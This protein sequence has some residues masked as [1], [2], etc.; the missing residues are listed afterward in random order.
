MD[1]KIVIT[2]AV[3]LAV[4]AGAGAV[5]IALTS[6]G[7]PQQEAPEPEQRAVKVVEST[8]DESKEDKGKIDAEKIEGIEKTSLT[9]EEVKKLGPYLTDRL[10]SGENVGEWKLSIAEVPDYGEPGYKAFNLSV[11]NTGKTYKLLIG[12]V[13]TLEEG[14]AEP[15]AG[16]PAPEPAAQPQAPA[17]SEAQAMQSQAPSKF[18]S[19]QTAFDDKT[20]WPLSSR[21]KAEAIIGKPIADRL[22]ADVNAYLAEGGIQVAKEADLLVPGEVTSSSSSLVEFNVLALVG[23]DRIVLKCSYDPATLKHAIVWQP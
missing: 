14:K 10:Y 2:A 22:L 16:E 20:A 3:A 17:E 7:G 5:G 4:G 12:D 15:H 13:W 9:E 19:T 6:S 21:D 11:A 23:P 1:K 8:W 18:N